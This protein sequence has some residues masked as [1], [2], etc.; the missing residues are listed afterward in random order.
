MSMTKEKLA[1]TL[2]IALT[3]YGWS[4]EFNGKRIDLF[5]TRHQALAEVK[6]RGAALTGKGTRSTV[7]VEG[8]ALDHASRFPLFRPSWPK[9]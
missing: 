7:V 3:E 6:R 4:V 8:S 9:R 1:T 2:T 5:Q